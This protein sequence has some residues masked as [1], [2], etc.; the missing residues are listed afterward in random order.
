M[1]HETKALDINIGTHTNKVAFNVISSPTNP[2]V[3]GYHGLS[4]LVY[5]EISF[6]CTSE[7][8]IKMWEAYIQKIISVGENYHLDESCIK[9]FEGNKYLGNTEDVKSSKALFVGTNAFMQATKKGNAFLIYVLPTS[10]W[11]MT[12][13]TY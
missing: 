7:S 11:K 5:K 1:T 4:G 3:F 8:N 2:I 13:R 6:W 9:L 12:F 10:K